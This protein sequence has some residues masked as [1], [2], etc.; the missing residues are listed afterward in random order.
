MKKVTDT[1]MAE[2]SRNKAVRGYIIR[3]LVKGFN[4][5]ALTGFKFPHGFRSYH[6]PGY[7]Q[8]S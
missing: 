1:E 7:K 5:A 6:F 8:V 3:C 4:N 2:V